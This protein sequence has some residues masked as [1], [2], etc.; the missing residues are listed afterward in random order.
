MAIDS[1]WLVNKPLRQLSYIRE[2]NTQKATRYL[3]T[4]ADPLRAHT[5]ILLPKTF[6]TKRRNLFCPVLNAKTEVSCSLHV[7]EKVKEFERK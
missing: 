1:N 2:N 3:Y 7:E 4:G 6:Q 5:H